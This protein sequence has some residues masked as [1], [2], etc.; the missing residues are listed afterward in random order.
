MARMKTVNGV[1]MPLTAEEEIADDAEKKAW[2]DG[3]PTREMEQIRN[4]RNRLLAE[5]DWTGNSDVT[6]TDA[7]KTY[8]KALRDYP[9]SNSTYSDDEKDWPTKPE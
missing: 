6:M 8:R 5:T 7:M 9:A 3:A 4:H 1:D 2:A